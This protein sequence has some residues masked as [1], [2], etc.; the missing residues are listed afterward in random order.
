M[1]RIFTLLMIFMAAASIGFAQ[2]EVPDSSFEAGTPNSYWTEASTNFGTPICEF[3][4][5]GNCGGGCVAHS[6][7][8]FAWF[9]GYGAFEEGSVDQD[10]SFLSGSSATLTFWLVMPNRPVAEMIR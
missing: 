1:K 3:S 5:C 10:I 6:G 4:V 7:S 2:I 8:Y 9:G